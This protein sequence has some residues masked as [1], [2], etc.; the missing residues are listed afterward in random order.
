MT[1]RG[2]SLN[3]RGVEDFKMMN[4]AWRRELH[5]FIQQ[6]M[7]ICESDEE[8]KKALRSWYEQPGE[9]SAKGVPVIREIV[10]NAL[11]EEKEKVR[12]KLIYLLN[13]LFSWPMDEKEVSS[14]V[15]RILEE[16]DRSDQQVEKIWKDRKVVEPVFDN[17]FH[18]E[19]RRQLTSE[20]ADDHEDG[21]LVLIEKILSDVGFFQRYPVEVG[22]W[23]Q[24]FLAIERYH[25]EE[26]IQQEKRVDELARLKNRLD[27]GGRIETL[28][29]FLLYLEDRLIKAQDREI[30]KLT[31]ETTGFL[32]G[33]VRPELFPHVNLEH[34]VY[35]SL[36]A[37]EFC[38]AENV[39]EKDVKRIKELKTTREMSTLR[40]L[41]LLLYDQVVAE[42]MLPQASRLLDRLQTLGFSIEHKDFRD[43]YKVDLVPLEKTL[44]FEKKRLP[45]FLDVASLTG[46]IS[47]DLEGQK[48]LIEEIFMQETRKVREMLLAMGEAKTVP[49]PKAQLIK[50]ASLFAINWKLAMFEDE[51]SIPEED[52]LK[53]DIQDFLSGPLMKLIRPRK[54]YEFKNKNAYQE[55]LHKELA[56]HLESIKRVL[57]SRKVES[58]FD[59]RYFARWLMFRKLLDVLATGK[60]DIKLERVPDATDF[61][62]KLT[63]DWLYD[64]AR[65]ENCNLE[66]AYPCSPV[67]FY[68]FLMSYFDMNTIAEQVSSCCGEGKKFSKSD[69]EEEVLNIIPWWAATIYRVLVA[70]ARKNNGMPRL[71]ANPAEIPNIVKLFSPAFCHLEEIA[72]KRGKDYLEQVGDS[73]FLPEFRPV[74]ETEDELRAY[75]KHMIGEFVGGSDIESFS[76]DHDLRDLKSFIEEKLGEVDIIPDPSY[77][78]SIHSIVLEEIQP[79]DRALLEELAEYANQLLRLL[80]KSN[81]GGC[82]ESSCLN[83]AYALLRGRKKPNE[84][85]QMSA[86]EQETI[87]RELDAVVASLGD[88]GA[89]TVTTPSGT[90]GPGMYEI[91]EELARSYTSVETIMARRI[92]WEKLKKIF[93]ERRAKLQIYKKPSADEIYRMFKNFLGFEASERLRSDEREFLIENGEKY[94]EA[95]WKEFFD[96]YDWFHRIQVRR[97]SAPYLEEHDA[98]HR[99]AAYYRDKLYL[100][101]L[102]DFDRSLVLNYR[103]FKYMDGFSDWWNEDLLQMSDPEYQIQDW[104]DF[105]KIIKNAYWHQESSPSAGEI[106]EAIR[107]ELDGD[108]ELSDAARETLQIFLKGIISERLSEFGKEV[109]LL[110]RLK[111]GE[112]IDNVEKLEGVLNFFVKD[113]ALKGDYLPELSLTNR[114][115]AVFSELDSSGINIDPELLW[116]WESLPEQVREYIGQVRTVNKDE[117]TNF[118]RSKEGMPWKDMVS[119]RD[120][121]L[122]SYIFTKV[123]KLEQEEIELKLLNR[124]LD[125][126]ITGKEAMYRLTPG[127]LSLYVDRL[128]RVGKKADEILQEVEK[129]WDIQSEWEDQLMEDA[130]THLIRQRQLFVTIGQDVENGYP[131]VLVRLIDDRIRTLHAM[132][133]ERLLHYLFILAKMEGNLDTLT[134]L[135]R[136]IRETS[137]IIEAAWLNF[138]TERSMESPKPVQVAKSTGGLPVEAT[139]LKKKDLFN[140]YLEEGLPRGEK[141]AITRAYW[142]LINIIRYYVLQ[143]HSSAQKEVAAGM[144]EKK[145]VPENVLESIKEEYSIEGLSEDALLKAISDQIKRLPSFEEEKIWIYTTVTARKFASQNQELLEIERQFFKKKNELLKAGE[146]EDFLPLAELAA[147]RGV[148]LGKV[149]EAVYYHLSDLLE[150]ERIKS[151]QRRIRQIVEQLEEKRS[152]IYHGWNN[153]EINRR[154]VFYILRL[155]QKEKKL[156]SWDD[157][158]RFIRDQRTL[159]IQKLKQSKA[160]DV[161]EIRETLEMRFRALLGVDLREIE[162]KSLEEAKSRLSMMHAEK[163]KE[164]ETTFA[165]DYFHVYVGYGDESSVALPNGSKTSS[166]ISVAS[167]E[168]KKAKLLLKISLEED[169]SEALGKLS[170]EASKKIEEISNELSRQIELLRESKE[171]TGIAEV[172]V[173]ENYVHAA[174]LEPQ[175]TANFSYLALKHLPTGD[176]FLADHLEAHA[177]MN[178]PQDSRIPPN[179]EPLVEEICAIR[180]SLEE[181]RNTYQS[182]D[183]VEKELLSLLDDSGSVLDTRGNA[184]KL[185]RAYMSRQDWRERD[186]FEMILEFLGDMPEIYGGLKDELNLLDNIRRE[187]HL[188]YEKII[189][190]MISEARANLESVAAARRFL[191]KTV[192]RG[193]KITSKSY[194]QMLN[195]MALALGIPDDSRGKVVQAVMAKAPV[196][197]WKALYEEGM[198]LAAEKGRKI[199]IKNFERASLFLLPEL[200]PGDLGHAR[201]CRSLIESTESYNK[202]LAGI[203][204][205]EKTGVELLLQQVDKFNRL[206]ENAEF[207]V[208]YT[209]NEIKWWLRIFYLRP[210]V[211]EAIYNRERRKDIYTVISGLGPR[212]YLPRVLHEVQSIFGYVTPEA[213]SN[214]VSVLG[215]DATDVIKV[216]ASYKEFSADPSGD[217]IIYICKGTA[218]F[219][220]GQPRISRTLSAVI[221]ADRG[222]VADCGIQYIE[223]DCF[224]V[225]H[226]APVVKAGDTFIP[227]VDP[228]SIPRL[229]E[230]LLK[231]VSYENRVSFLNRIKR[232]LTRGHKR[233][234]RKKL[235]VTGAIN[236]EKEEELIGQGVA[237][238]AQ[239]NLSLV[240]NGNGRDLGRLVPKSISFEYT[241]GHGINAIGSLILDEAN[242]VTAVLNY[243]DC[244]L[245]DAVKHTMKPLVVVKDGEVAVRIENAVYEL[246]Q[247]NS[248]TVVVETGDG[249]Y[250]SI[251]F[252]GPNARAVL[253]EERGIPT[254]RHKE[255]DPEFTRKQ[256]RVLLGFV[257]GVDPD[258][259]DSYIKH[260]GYKALKTVLG[261]NGG[262]RWTPE[263]II[264]QIKASNLRGRGGAGFPTGRKWEGLY[265]AVVTIDPKDENKDP[266]K[267]IVANGDEGDPGAFMDRTL[268]QEKP[269]LLVEG[270]IIAALAINARYG[271]IYVRKEYEDAVRRIENALFQARRRGFL[272]R[273]IC[274]IEGL[275]FDLEIRLGAGA[276][277]AG[278]KRAIMRAIEGKPAEPTLKAVSNSR[279]GLWGKPTLL[280]NVETFANVPLIIQRGGRW[281]KRQGYK[282]SGG[283]KIFSVAGIVKQTGLVEVRFGR[284]LKDI[285]NICGG[286]KEEKKLAGVQI[287]GPSGAI[288]SLTGIREY[289]LHT[290]L[291]FDIFNQVGA[292]LGSGGLVFIG[293]DD[294]VVRL[295]RHFT[296]WLEDESCGQCPSCLGGTASLGRTLDTILNGEG[297]SLHIH[298]LWAKGDAVKAGSQCGLGKTAA[299]PVTSA[300]RFFPQSFLHYLLMNPKL[301]R[302]ELFR[303]LEALRLLTRENVEIISKRKRVVVGYAFTLRKGMVATF[304]QLL[305]NIDQYKAPQDQQA[306]KFLQLLGIEE[307]EVGKWDITGNFNLEE[308]QKHDEVMKD[309]GYDLLRPAI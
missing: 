42:R 124:Y 244:A 95:G 193:R 269:H 239:G 225:C 12:N 139:S 53:K 249:G 236:L 172:C 8:R 143:M 135:L 178:E 66:E 296:D 235:V 117:L 45:I 256:D 260:G 162:N 113:I 168:G 68:K 86:D 226:M 84:C 164:L 131:R 211:V 309:V 184:R 94:I 303:C 67:R 268:I 146:G 218:C 150:D 240:G 20:I 18:Y 221:G 46:E 281:F 259:I 186:I 110:E 247:I 24:H 47:K 265:R 51:K 57:E 33:K 176:A 27:K 185:I 1:F 93:E 229:V 34:A 49:L 73:L 104:E 154:T 64:M 100:S 195:A 166:F 10:R 22:F 142:E 105:S 169:L 106:Y 237:I 70:M 97:Q 270:M 273:N 31:R 126:E 116:R 102:S 88:A 242:Q 145:I 175:R 220:R 224:G 9:V 188:E 294:D 96:T 37:H 108:I 250:A 130:L 107:E 279:R 80:P 133:K 120:A 151:F 115:N 13:S 39:P 77:P 243:P 118:Q 114:I 54:G 5:N 74:L 87:R 25:R 148:E 149:K 101:Q 15:S 288:L 254:R 217:I 40:D 291:D 205:P 140:K 198:R 255:E 200:K 163:L 232:V 65:E 85:Q 112:K 160:P 171:L 161:E 147:K 293:E 63:L 262:R 227:S 69:I 264:D 204:A 56:V 167:E 280:N 127:T 282:N 136:E 38:L 253:E 125:G 263:E 98:L 304:Y 72:L 71:P 89:G 238:D 21:G 83:F 274:G 212:A 223:M 277:V 79:S 214:I 192:P 266:I 156:P 90:S 299:N 4:Q 109:E 179:L 132:D 234:L 189:T 292:M 122:K 257:P 61:I 165:D 301:N 99:S 191:Q 289:L 59:F 26:A 196:E 187:D 11:K 207:P 174:H 159:R 246:G 194:E 203:Y 14:N 308:L 158:R 231:G 2:V 119:L 129:L 48:V 241:T 284:T 287:G 43:V 258:N 23:A 36:L 75:V 52:L 6:L 3:F 197:A 276:F 305:K 210:D 62:L 82:G 216:I 58:L 92:F 275:D 300:L 209:S 199:E 28:S 285:I 35:F 222:Q 32:S 155:Y 202:I 298:A 283:T 138:T 16:I 44:E 230:Q 295:A 267:L 261:L 121:I 181:I 60:G 208:N 215:L 245:E 272:G 286:I 173:W 30:E 297:Y 183:R 182:V 103:L 157:F 278:E 91:P 219:L 29:E 76:V 50:N 41:M 248:N 152:E 111:T 302:L 81:C 307:H 19:L 170:G 206:P 137:D 201:F 134:A 153:G 213:F 144:P 233:V 141:P 7:L 306:W 128:C 190:G 180:H 271:V 252:D 290:P 228:E 78:K 177:L 123:R 251:T 55:F 17:C